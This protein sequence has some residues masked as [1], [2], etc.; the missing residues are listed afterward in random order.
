MCPHCRAFIDKKDRVC[1]YCD[2]HM[3]PRA[4][5]LR[6]PDNLLGGLVPARR[7]ATGALLLINVALYLATVIVSSKAGNEGALM[8]LDSRTLIHF[9]AMY[10]PL[11]AMG[12]LWRLLTA[13]FL[14]GGLLH[15]F[16]NMWGF[17]DIGAQVEELFGTARMVVIYTISTVTGFLASFYFGGG[18][19]VGASAGIFGL[20]GAMI[21]LGTLHR[22][23]T[24]QYLKTVYTRMAV[25]GI[26][27]GFVIPVID[28]WAHMGGLAGG[29]A[30]AWA[31]GL[32]RRDNSLQDRI[33]RTVAIGCVLATGAAFLAM[34]ARLYK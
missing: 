14:H 8:N 32:E 6:M 27:I 1:P 4:I 12:E 21:A 34:A 23:A 10:R 9:G 29:F 20:I 26:V 30:V 17:M 5:D 33:W 22:N 18:L 19:S 31:S 25:Y 11:I 16:M 3:G 28:N 7:A 2:Y 15:I 13:G 24:A